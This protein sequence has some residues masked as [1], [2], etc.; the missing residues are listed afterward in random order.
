MINLKPIDFENHVFQHNQKSLVNQISNNYPLELFIQASQIGIGTTLASGSWD[1]SIRL[2]DVKT[3]QQKAKFNG[4]S[5]YVN[6]ICYSPDG[7]TLASGS[8]D[9]S[10]RLWDVKTG[11]Q[12]A[13]LDG[14]SNTVNTICYSPDGTTLASG[15]GDKSIR[16][17]DVK[18]GE[19]I[20]S[21][22]N[23]YKNI[24]AQF[25]TPIFNNNLIE[26]N[27]SS[28][29]TI[30]LISQQLRFQSQGAL[31]LR[32]EFSNQ[33]GIDLRTLFKQRGSIILEN[34]MELQKR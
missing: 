30:L 6:S 2:W 8:V 11:Q 25:Q 24:L 22:N 17:W 20:V 1:K 28:I 3:G 34:E 18:T 29:I 9:N 14:H 33:S 26:N 27:V 13:K 19:E 16:L 10:I 12:K 7:T 31:I 23:R 32:G 21:S 4:H 15:S 5:H